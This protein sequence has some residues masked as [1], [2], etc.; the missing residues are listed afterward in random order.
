MRIAILVLREPQ[1]SKREPFCVPCEY[2]VCFGMPDLCLLLFKNHGTCYLSTLYVLMHVAVVFV[3]FC[4]VLF[5]FAW[6]QERQSVSEQDVFEGYDCIP[7][8]V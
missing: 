7:C 4:F 5:C 3:L 1:H 2:R 6:P 8:R